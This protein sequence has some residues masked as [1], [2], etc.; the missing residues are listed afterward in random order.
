MPEKLIN[1]T[2]DKEVDVNVLK[3]QNK[4]TYAQVTDK[5]IVDEAIKRNGG[6]WSGDPR[7]Y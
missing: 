3:A 4:P 5:S 7:W 6:V 2:I 1:Y